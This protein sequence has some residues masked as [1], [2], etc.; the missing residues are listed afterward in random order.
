M[1]HAFLSCQHNSLSER[2]SISDVPVPSD[3]VISGLAAQGTMAFLVAELTDNFLRRSGDVLALDYALFMRAA[4]VLCSNPLKRSHLRT[5]IREV[6]RQKEMVWTYCEH[7]KEERASLRKE[8]R[9]ALSGKPVVDDVKVYTKQTGRSHRVNDR[10]YQQ[11]YGN[12]FPTT[13]DPPTQGTQSTQGSTAQKTK[14]RFD[15][16][17]DHTTDSE[18]TTGDQSEDEGDWEDEGDDGD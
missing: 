16:A 12:P 18:D 15:D 1:N 10:L 8:F 11:L 17:E 4:G 14:P 3:A 5:L 2:P 13:L 9:K 6:I 7:L